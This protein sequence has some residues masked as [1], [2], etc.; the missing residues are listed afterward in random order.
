MKRTLLVASLV[1]SFVFTVK[2][3]EGM[4]LLNQLSQLNLKEKGLEIPVE[5][6]YRPGQI[7]LA[8]AVVNLGGASAELVSPDGLILTN[9]HVAFGAVQRA[10][11]AGTDYLTNGFL[12]KTRDEELPAPGY[13]ARVLL[14]MKDVTD[15]I[16]KGMDKIKDPVKRMKAIEKR[17]KQMEEEIEKQREDF[18]ARIASMYSGKQY[19]LFKYQR[20]EDVRMVFI[21]PRAIGNYGGDVDN[22]M[23]PR[24]TGDFSFLR[25][26]TSPD[27]KGVPY[28]KENVP[29]KPKR[30]IKIARTPIKEGDF[31]FIIGFPGRTNRYSTSFAI[32]FYLNKVYP[33]SISE[34]QS[35]INMLDEIGKQSKELEI[36][37]VGTTK[38]LNNSMKNYQGNLEGM[39]RIHLLE[40]KKELE[41]QVQQ[42][43]NSD[44]R[45][46]KQY[47]DLLTRFEKKFK[48]SVQSYER[49]FFLT[50][51]RYLAGTIPAIANSIYSVA[52]ERAKPEDERNPIFSEK[53]VQRS[54]KRLKY[55]YMSYAPEIDKALLKRMLLKLKAL[56]EDQRIKGLDFIFKKYASVDDFIEQAYAKT[57]LTDV[58]FASSLFEKSLEELNKMDDPFIRMA[59][60]LQPEIEKNRK[61]EERDKAELREL[62]KQWIE[63]LMAFQNKPFYPDANGTIR[64]TYGKISGYTPRDAV[65]YKPFTTLTGV[66]EKETG[67]WPFIV[68]EKLKQLYQAKDFC[69]WQDKTLKDVPV[70][71]LN[72]CDITGGNS[73][74]PVF[75]AK[76]ELIGI[77]FDGNWE[78]LTGD[79]QFLD[80]IQRAI[81]VDIRYVLFVTE[82]FAEAHHLLKELGIE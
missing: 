56:P 64:F 7:G 48:K 27:G 75:N 33:M 52:Y 74:S 15:Q 11:T 34:F 78:A 80:G 13:V 76:G 61:Q 19:I 10:S 72:E 81:N 3:D 63:L 59:K 25:I 5:D 50:R 22:W 66:M 53:D 35:I 37:A 55:R 18:D 39:K 16:L 30:W 9:H 60:A 45:L 79:W 31:T 43:V 24:H 46:K 28:A 21:P 62:N 20:F 36:K 23:W 82:K 77:A 51:F 2:A 44:P 40:K 8:S 32:D 42:F 69:Q 26:Y 4:W 73:G 6:I 38:W 14:E 70:A 17:M 49:N 68:P 57:K 41:K 29:F 47:G 1:L 67:E 54:V 58:K 12:A 71:F 65:W